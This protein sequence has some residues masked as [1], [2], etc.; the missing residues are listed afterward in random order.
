MM[1]EENKILVAEDDDENFL[2]LKFLMKVKQIPV[3]RAKT[4]QEAVEIFLDNRNI[5][6]ILMDMKMP[7]MDGFEA[8]RIIRKSNPEI[9]II[10]VTAFVMMGDEEKVRQAGCNDYLPK[11]FTPEQLFDVLQRFLPENT[12]AIN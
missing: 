9:P 6:L 2:F 3:I 7:D 10:A 11:P 4:G 5:R 8:T 12:H 1:Y